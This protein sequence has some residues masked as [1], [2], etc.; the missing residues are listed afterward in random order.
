MEQNLCF[1]IFLGV[2]YAFIE[3]AL[4]IKSFFDPNLI[5]IGFL[6]VY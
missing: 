5:D 3:K 6:I 4:M 2:A 1:F